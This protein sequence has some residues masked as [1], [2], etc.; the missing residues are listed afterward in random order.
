VRGVIWLE[1]LRFCLE[2]GIEVYESANEL[3]L[4]AAK[5]DEISR[6]R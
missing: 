2:H 6:S 4:S 3:S 1:T 5:Q